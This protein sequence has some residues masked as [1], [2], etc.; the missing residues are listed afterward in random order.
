M[1]STAHEITGT[2]G[3]LALALGMTRSRLLARMSTSDMI[4]SQESLNS[5]G[6]TDGS[7]DVPHWPWLD[8][9]TLVCHIVELYNK[10]SDYS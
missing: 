2:H 5:V 3:I 6:H 8:A 10:D 1:H 4:R 9:D 7:A